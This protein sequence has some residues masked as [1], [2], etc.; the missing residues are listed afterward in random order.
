[1]TLSGT[2][3]PSG[4][5]GVFLFFKAGFESNG[6]TMATFGMIT[7]ETAVGVTGRIWR[8]GI[9]VEV[10]AGTRGVWGIGVEVTTVGVTD[11]GA[12]G[13]DTMN[14]IGQVSVQ[15]LLF[16]SHSIRGVESI[17]EWCGLFGSANKWVH[18]YSN[19]S[20]AAKFEWHYCW[21]HSWLTLSWLS[22]L[23]VI[24]KYY[25]SASRAPW[26]THNFPALQL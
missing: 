6:A 25:P 17:N 2:I 4:K 10:E 13:V 9:I 1:M 20:F 5:Q 14:W 3:N 7:L 22:I 15:E 8:A 18:L 11:T 24:Q 26:I 23:P 19:V 21:H 16:W 12:T